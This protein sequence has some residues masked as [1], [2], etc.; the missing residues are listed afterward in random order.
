MN[1]ISKL[2]WPITAPIKFIQEHFKTVLFLTILYFI[3]NSTDTSKLQQPNLQIVELNGPIIMVDDVLRKIEKAKNDPL[4]QGVLLKVNSP[5]GAIA[6]SI[7]VAYAIKELNEIKPVVA[8]ASGVMASGSYYA[9]IWAEKIIANPGSVIGSIG[10]IIQSVDTSELMTK[11]GIKSQVVKVGDYKEA[12]TPTR[13]W[14]KEEKDELMKVTQNNYDM[15]VNDVAN[16]RGLKAQNH[17]EFADAH[18]FT[19]TQAKNIGLI[20]EVATISKAK[21]TVAKLSGVSTPIWA[22]EDK[23]DKFMEKMLNSMVANISNSITGLQ[24]Y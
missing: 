5:G 3:F 17:K 24:V 11:I 19:S 6:P 9:S 14:S 8:Y 15:F 21:H 18:I 13:Q 23:V 10:V 7:E 1:F 20:D 12:G 22:K 4:I 2:F 16:A